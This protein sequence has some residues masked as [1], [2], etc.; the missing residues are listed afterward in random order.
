[1]IRFCSASILAAF[2]FSAAANSAA[3]QW[4]APPQ[5]TP[6]AA[7]PWND[8]QQTP[9]AAS[10]WNAA[11]QQE[12][13]C[14]QAFGKLRDDAQKKAAAIR[15]ASERKAEPKEACGL[16]NSFSA[17]EAKLIKY[18][19][20]N[21]ASCGI[22]PEVVTGLKKQHLKTTDIQTKVCRAAA[23]GPR[24]QGPSLSD[25]L[26]AGAVPDVSNIRTGRGTYDTLT[27]TPL[28]K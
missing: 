14:V 11:P 13:P 17:S 10:P 9:A 25:T 26:S 8:P 23:A 16:F 20:D 4:A 7:S 3:A 18:A 12:P 1:L 19:A 6:P 28:G 22:P 15:A 27:G 24:L 5:Q 21:A 2:V